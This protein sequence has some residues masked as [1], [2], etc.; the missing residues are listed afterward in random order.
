MTPLFLETPGV[1]IS[2]RNSNAEKAAPHAIR[3]LKDQQQARN[4]RDLQTCET[5]LAE[6]PGLENPEYCT[7]QAPF[8]TAIFDG[9]CDYDCSVCEGGVGTSFLQMCAHVETQFILTRNGDVVSNMDCVQYTLGCTERLCLEYVGTSSCTVTLDGTACNSC[10]WVLCE[11]GSRKP[12][13]DCSNLV[14]GAGVW[15]TCSNNVQIPLSSLFAPLSGSFFLVDECFS[16]LPQQEQI[17]EAT[18]PPSRAPIMEPA[19]PPSRAPV[20]VPVDDSVNGNVFDDTTLRAAV[21]LWFSDR[22]T[23]IETYG[24][25]GDWDVS[26]VSTMKRLFQDEEEFNDNISRWNTSNV[27]TMELLFSGATLFDQPLTSWDTSN[28]ANMNSTFSGATL[29]N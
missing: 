18:P 22:A 2:N 11:F 15:N 5:L 19:P 3:R 4:H 27:N 26:S 29:F 25:I 21:D 17:I 8:G 16:Q 9:N 1:R 13:V 24:P 14:A 23:A 20:M 6:P 28:V 10:D 12:L 7:C